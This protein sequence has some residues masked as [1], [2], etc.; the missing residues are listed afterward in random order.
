[1]QIRSAGNGNSDILI[2]QNCSGKVCKWAQVLDWDDLVVDGDVS[3]GTGRVDRWHLDV[4][5]W[6]CGN[7]AVGHEI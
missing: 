6:L 3:L 7:S 4:G 5:H 1:M 2:S